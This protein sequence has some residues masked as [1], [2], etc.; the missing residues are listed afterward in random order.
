[1]CVDEKSRIQALDPAQP[2]LRMAPGVAEHRAHSDVRH[3]TCPLFA[4][5]DIATGAELEADI[6][7]FI[8]ARNENPKPKKW[9]KPVDDILAAVK[10]FC[11]QTRQTRQTLC[12]E[13]WIVVTGGVG[14]SQNTTIAAG[15]PTETKTFEHLS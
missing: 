9:V 2:V 1:M 3:G 12:G 7:A 11:Q 4:A 13:L 14:H 6:A 15:A 5:L 8:N 10:R